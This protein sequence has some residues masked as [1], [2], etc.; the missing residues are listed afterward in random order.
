MLGCAE[1]FGL[2]DRDA[3]LAPVGGFTRAAEGVA[4]VVAA[5][6]S[7][8]PRC[9]AP[10]GAPRRSGPSLCSKAMSARAWVMLY[11][12]RVWTSPT[13]LATAGALPPPR[14]VEPPSVRESPQPHSQPRPANGDGKLLVGWADAPALSVAR[15]LRNCARLLAPSPS[16]S[17]SSSAP[18][19]ANRASR[20]LAGTSANCVRQQRAHLS[21]RPL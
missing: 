16:R 19:L 3:A 10:R 2:P 6:G 14:R 1:A 12:A 17:P 8:L 5:A 4:A 15:R 18:S 13:A 21:E 20:S 7:T 9:S 11:N